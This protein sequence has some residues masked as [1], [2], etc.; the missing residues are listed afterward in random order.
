[1]VECDIEFVD[2]LRAEGIAYLGA[3]ERDSHRA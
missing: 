3:V 2:R 1:M